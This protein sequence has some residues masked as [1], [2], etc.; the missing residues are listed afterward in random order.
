ME[1]QPPRSAYVPPHARKASKWNDPRAQNTPT[2]GVYIISKDAF[3]EYTC[4]DSNVASGAIGYIPPD[5]HFPN[6]TRNDLQ[7]TIAGTKK[8]KF[9]GRP[10]PAEFVIHVHCEGRGKFVPGAVKINRHWNPDF[11]LQCPPLLSS[12]IIEKHKDELQNLAES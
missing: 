3:N 7:I 12:A 4:T 10:E 1:E 11:P 5:A 6:R 8:Q 2:L 9:G